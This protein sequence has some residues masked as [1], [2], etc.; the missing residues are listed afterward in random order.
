MPHVMNGHATL[1]QVKQRTG[2]II[3]G[4]RA[5]GRGGANDSCRRSGRAK[6]AQHLWVASVAARTFEPSARASEAVRLRHR[7]AQDAGPY[8]LWH[9][10]RRRE[11]PAQDRVVGR[12]GCAPRSPPPVCFAANLIPM[13]PVSARDAVRV[14]SLHLRAALT[15]SQRAVR[16][17]PALSWSAHRRASSSSTTS[18]PPLTVRPPPVS[19]SLAHRLIARQPP[20][21]NMREPLKTF[22]KNKAIMQLA[23]VEK[24]NILISLS[25]ARVDLQA[26]LSLTVALVQTTSSAYTISPT[27]LC[28]PR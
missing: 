19:L 20:Q 21:V 14:Y 2:I 6:T 23:V 16:T 24:Y 10:Q 5:G 27:S 17:R 22:A 7:E 11:A 8:G 15:S 9:P 13:L 1:P 25:G 26:S 28:A 12:L 18:F 3:A 4:R